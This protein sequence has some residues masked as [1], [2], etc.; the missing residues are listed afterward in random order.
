MEEAATSVYDLFNI[1]DDDQ[2]RLGIYR[3][4]PS[5]EKPAGMSVHEH[6]GNVLPVQYLE[7]HANP[8]SSPYATGNVESVNRLLNAL[9][10]DKV[11]MP[12]DDVPLLGS[13]F[14]VLTR[15]DGLRLGTRSAAA[16]L[17][18]MHIGEGVLFDVYVYQTGVASRRK[19]GLA[20]V[21]K[22]LCTDPKACKD[23]RVVYVSLYNG[24]LENM[25][26]RL[27]TVS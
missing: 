20:W 21:G 3:G 5:L 8:W 23:H 4:R 24:R 10:S 26:K 6:F 22:V 18:S 1:K 16:D 14:A 12:D 25:A 17:I 13:H 2:V 7:K 15:N 11:A 19:H 27:M 9:K